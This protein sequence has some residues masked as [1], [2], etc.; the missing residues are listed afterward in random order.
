MNSIVHLA[1][2]D[3][4]RATDVDPAEFLAHGVH[5]RLVSRLFVTAANQLGG[6]NGRSFGD[7]HHF[8]D[9]NA[10]QALTWLAVGFPVACFCRGHCCLPADT[11]RA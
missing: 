3:D 9:Q 11:A 2:A 7:P 1:F 4:D 8:H 6:G 5:R 10:F